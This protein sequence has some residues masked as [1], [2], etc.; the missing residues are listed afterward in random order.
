LAYPTRDLEISSYTF[1]QHTLKEFKREGVYSIAY[2]EAGFGGKLRKMNYDIHVGSIL[3]FPGKVMAFLASLI[4]ASLPITG[5]LIWYGRK[6]KKKA[7]KK[8]PV[9]TE[10]DN[11]S[12]G[13]KPSAKLKVKRVEKV[14]E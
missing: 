8:A 1:D 7:V 3:G 9:L 14:L 11:K 5:F 2:E 6:F 13:F 10:G 12:D 4:G